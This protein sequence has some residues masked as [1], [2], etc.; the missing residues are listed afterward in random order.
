MVSG[1]I[2]FTAAATKVTAFGLFEYCM[3]PTGGFTAPTHYHKIMHHLL[4]DVSFLYSPNICKLQEHI[5]LATFTVD[6][7]Y[8]V[9]KAVF[10]RLQNINISKN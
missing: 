1:R 4:S 2:L 7:Y 6:E 10:E 3:M 9:L 5:L 8:L